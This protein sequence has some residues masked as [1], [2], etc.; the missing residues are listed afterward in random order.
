MNYTYTVRRVE[1]KQQFVGIVYHVEGRDDF[2]KNFATDD[3]S[4]A[5][6]D[7][8]VSDFAPEVAAYWAAYD[9]ASEDSEVEAGSSG[10]GSTL[11]KV[12]VDAPEADIDREELVE[13]WV[14][15]LE[16]GTSTQTWAVVPLDDATIK[17]NFIERIAAQRFQKEAEGVLWTDNAMRTYFFDSSFDSQQRFVSVRALIS[18]GTRTDGDVWKCAEMIGGQPQLVFRPMLNSELEAISD[19]VA[20][21]VQRCFDAEAACAAQIMAGN[22][23][24]NYQAVYDAL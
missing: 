16:A 6:I 12:Y 18:A 20:Q 5:A 1:P 2:F 23:D 4:S 11:L 9:A 8:L 17:A 22:F 3:F 14:D 7:Q 10:S 13:S 19:R 15:D 21:H 24:V